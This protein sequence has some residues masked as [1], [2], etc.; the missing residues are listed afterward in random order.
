MVFD[1]V[2]Q[3]MF[4]TDVMEY[5]EG[6]KTHLL[7]VGDKVAVYS[8]RFSQ[9][10]GDGIITAT[11]RARIKVR[12]GFKRYFGISWSRGNEKY[13]LVR[14]ILEMVR[15]HKTTPKS[16]RL[17]LVARRGSIAGPAEGGQLNVQPV[18]RVVHTVA[19]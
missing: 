17:R 2:Y 16:D 13:V 7:R 9:W 12:Y 3:W 4:S 11:F 18:T 19:S 5:K 1:S 10:F 15:P 8:Q 14:D 6:K